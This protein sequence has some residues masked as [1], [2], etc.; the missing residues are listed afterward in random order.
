MIKI[1]PLRK[2]TLQ[3]K[4]NLLARGLLGFTVFSFLEEISSCETSGNN[5]EVGLCHT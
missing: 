2:S 4:Q 5:Q 3:E 1:L